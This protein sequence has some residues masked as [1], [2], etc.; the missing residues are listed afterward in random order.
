M[1]FLLDGLDAE[2]Y[3]RNYSDRV[4]LV[5]IL[6]YFRT[7][8]SGMLLVAGTIALA[9]VA[10]AA[11]PVLISKGVDA[12]QSPASIR[13]TIGWIVVAILISGVLSWTFNFIRR[14]YSAR[15]VGNVV[16]QIRR[17]AFDAVMARD[18]SFYDETPS[19]K[20]VSRVTSDT[21]DFA[22]V[23]T[24]ALNLL[25]QIL[26]LFLI[27]IVLFIISPTLALLA[28]SIMPFIVLVAL[29]FRRIARRAT[30]RSQRSLARVNANVQEVVRGIAV[31]KNFRKENK[32][33]N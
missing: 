21:E 27:I 29:G 22:T 12:V 5:R 30:Q 33:S 2:G 26:L 11:L 9:S 14:Y 16:L 18:M 4:L 19:G 31:A 32:M 3:D 1:G 23:V 7:E 17:D 24:L 25:S 13:L 8:R 20:I 28:F 6:K 15:A 10:D